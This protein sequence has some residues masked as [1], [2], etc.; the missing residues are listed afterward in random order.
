MTQT[1]SGTSAL[2]RSHLPFLLREKIGICENIYKNRK[3]DKN[4]TAI[5]ISCWTEKLVIEWMNLLV[6]LWRRK[7]LLPHS[8][9]TP[10]SV[11]SVLV[12]PL[13]LLTLTGCTGSPRARELV[14]RIK[15]ECY[16]KVFSCSLK[17]HVERWS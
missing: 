9:Q 13:P 16:T 5:F 4:I 2:Q 6:R 1:R 10:L 8:K 15:Y 17:S 7:N 11:T 14:Y 12:W 3:S